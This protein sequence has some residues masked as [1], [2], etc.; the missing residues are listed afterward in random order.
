[1]KERVLQGD[2]WGPVFASKQ[3]DKF[4]KEM[5]DESSSFMFWYKSIVPIPLLAQCN[6]V[7]GISEA[8]F[9]SVQLSSFLNVKAADKHSQFGASK[10]KSMIVSR[11]APADFLIPKLKVDSWSKEIDENNIIKEVF[12]GKLPIENV[13]TFVYLGAVI[14]NDGSNLPDILRKRNKAIGTQKEILKLLKNLGPYTF[15][16]ARTY[17]LSLIRSS[18]L[19]SGETMVSITEEEYRTIERFEE[20]CLKE[21]LNTPRT[22][23][24]YFIYLMYAIIPARNQIHRMKLSYLH[25]IMQQPQYSILGQGVLLTPIIQLR[26][27]GDLLL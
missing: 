25:Y 16:C 19:Y 4:G 2:T 15:V 22:C 13:E 8:G 9:K 7:L 1:M 27:T 6:D 3:V 14:S 26:V 20:S 24:T 12:E 5:L 17:F 11:K 21:Y 10:C 18:I 23:P